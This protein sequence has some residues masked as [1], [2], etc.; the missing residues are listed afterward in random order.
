MNI[1]M[2][3][4]RFSVLLLVGALLFVQAGWAQRPLETSLRE[5]VY[6]LASD[7]LAGRSVGTEGEKKAAAYINRCLASYGLDFIYP[8]GIQDFSVVGPQGDTLSSQN[9]VGIISGSDPVLKEEYIV[10]GAHYDHLGAQKITIDSKESLLLYPG[11]DDNA[12]GVSI[13]LELARS[14]AQQPYLFKR[15][16]VFVTFGA[17]EMGMIGSWYF[18]NRAFSPI[19]QVVLMLNLDMLGRSGAKN[20]FNAYTVKPHAALSGALHYVAGL[21]LIVQPKVFGTDY[22]PSDH[23]IFHQKNI[24]TVLF[25]S[26]IHLDYH[27]PGDKP[28]LLDYEEMERRK[29]YI[30]SFLLQMANDDSWSEEKRGVEV[31]AK[32]VYTMAHVDI[33]PKFQKGDEQKFVKT[34]INKYLKYPQIAVS[35]GIQGRVLVQFIVEADGSVTQV[36][37]VESVDQLLD[38]EAVRVIQASPKWSAGVKNG[39]SVRTQC[40]VPV[41]FVL[42]HR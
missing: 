29:S 26:G 6:V 8:Q 22:F 38:D 18:V 24:P 23:Q 40:V 2:P 25:T 5:H 32:T 10:I 42:K 28:N 7:S 30:Y 35:Q 4:V 13:L 9:I 14:A 36:E 39:R 17:E 20:P 19:N 33:P 16:L 1:F 3:K 31:S 12:S 37:V 34:W 15:S 21:P 11:A 41:Y 27:T